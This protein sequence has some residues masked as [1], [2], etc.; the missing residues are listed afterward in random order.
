[1]PA[2]I[3]E[4]HPQ[5]HIPLPRVPVDPITL[6]L[7]ENGL[8]AA[9]EQMDALLFRTAMS[10]I[11]R[12][13]RDGFPVITSRDGKLLAGQFGS[14]VHGFTERYDGTIEEGDIFLTSDPYE[15]DGAISHANDWLVCM[16]VFKDG[17]LINW[18]AMFGHMAD[19]GGKVPGSIP[20]DS[21]QIFEEGICIPPV[22]IF[23]KGVLQEEI[24]RVILHNC[25]IPEWNRGDF[26]SIVAACRMAA[27]RCVEMAERFGEA[28]YVSALHDLLDRNRR[29]MQ[30]LI[31]ETITEEKRHFEDYICDDGMGMGPYKIACSLWREGERIVFDFSDTDPQSVGAINFLLSEQMFRMFCGQFMINFFDPQIL[32]ND[33][34]F[35]LVDVRIPEGCLLKPLKPA[36]LSSRTHALARIFDVLSG[37]LGQSNPDYMCAAGFSD[38]PHLMYSGYDKDGDWFLLFQIGFGGIPGKPGGDGPDGHSLWPKFMNVPNEFIESYFP[39]RIEC[40][41]TIPD[42][43]GPGLHRGGNAMNVGYRFLA[44]GV[45]SLH[46]DRW[47]TYPWGVR[48]GLPGGRSTKIIERTDGRRELLPSKCDRVRVEVGDKLLF[49]TWGGGGWGNPLERPAHKV[50]ADVDRGL[51]TREGA[52]R[53]GVVLRDD[54][55]VD[56]PA[57]TALR[58]ELARQRG[59]SE[60]FDFGG[61]IAELKARCKAETGFDPPQP[62]TFAAWVRARQGKTQVVSHVNGR[63]PVSAST[64]TEYTGEIP[65][66]EPRAK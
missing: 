46:D 43:G 12:D 3:I 5:A 54:L 27:S 60:L 64:E 45:L 14:P 15:C 10:P 26:H 19:I 51:V 55:S 28:V 1:M 57:T 30:K 42:S 39:V 32:L 36:A 24:L 58:T 2:T 18:S 6:D 48:G 13:Q 44:P 41:E 16:P 63:Q 8:V 33:G 11:I 65:L 47:L 66:P 59:P 4:T 37:L 40:Y 25:R 53:Y 21:E 49:K 34:F 17:R 61:N 22:K 52:K 50:A 35:D 62:P 23:S 7:I 20:I 9:R 31:S 29:A 38:S 56:E